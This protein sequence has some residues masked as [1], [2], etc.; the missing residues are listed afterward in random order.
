M[1]SPAYLGQN[2]TNEEGILVNDTCHEE[3]DKILDQMIFLW[4][5]IDENTCSQKNPY[6]E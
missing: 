5:E 6:D 2:Y 1:G 4:R 3:W